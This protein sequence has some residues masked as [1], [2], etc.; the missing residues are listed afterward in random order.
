MKFP[1]KISLILFSPQNKESSEEYKKEG[2]IKDK[3]AT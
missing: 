3:V 1:H 2:G